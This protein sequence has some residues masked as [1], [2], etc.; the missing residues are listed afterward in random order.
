MPMLRLPCPGPVSRLVLLV[1]SF[2]L[3]YYGGTRGVTWCAVIGTALAVYTAALC[4]FRP[5]DC[6]KDR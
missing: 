1:G 5:G 3:L 4:I 6:A 2:P